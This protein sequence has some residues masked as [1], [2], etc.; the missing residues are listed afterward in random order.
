MNEDIVDAE[1]RRN[2]LRDAIDSYMGQPEVTLDFIVE[3]GTNLQ[4]PLDRWD[5]YDA[6]SSDLWRVDREEGAPKNY[7]STLPGYLQGKKLEA[8]WEIEKLITTDPLSG[9]LKKERF[10]ELY[11]ASVARASGGP[12]DRSTDGEEP[13]LTIG[14]FDINK[15]KTLND[16][17]GHLVGDD[18][19][20]AFG[21]ALKKY[22]RKVDHIGRI[23]GDE[24]S[25]LMHGESQ[26]SA[27]SYAKRIVNGINE[28]VT[29]EIRRAHPEV[30]EDITVSL[31]LAIY[32]VH[33][34][35]A[36]ELYDFADTA[37]C[38]AKE[39][40]KGLKFMVYTPG[41]ER[42]IKAAGER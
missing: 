28:D 3:A 16:K 42:P 36:T 15:F 35:N 17:Y 41:I 9:I 19:I 21:K 8:R 27:R 29:S 11:E 13:H 38:N 32:G 2:P 39:M 37:M 33:S 6:V 7:D 5:F 30:Q 23:G 40:E 31:G 22:S 34:Q 20:A 18:V 14:I 4:N 12:S 10:M 24:F 1:E 25:I 26:E